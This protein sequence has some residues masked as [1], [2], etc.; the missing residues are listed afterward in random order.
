MTRLLKL[1]KRDLEKLIQIRS[2]ENN[3][4]SQ[5]K[6]EISDNQEFNCKHDDDM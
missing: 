1:I 5:V 2:T 6:L 4:D 3:D